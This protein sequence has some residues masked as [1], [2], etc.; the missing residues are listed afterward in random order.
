MNDLASLF[1]GVSLVCAALGAVSFA[2]FSVWLSAVD[3]RSRR[4]PNRVV[5]WGTVLTLG[6]TLASGLLAVAGSDNVDALWRLISAA[7]AAT[8]LAL[9]FLALWL[10][11][12]GGFGAGD[13]K[14]APLVGGF[15]VYVGGETALLICVMVAAGIAFAWGVVLRMRRGRVDLP[16]APCLFGGAW[17]GIL[18]AGLSTGV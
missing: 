8:V 17:V 7:V 16:F 11:F 6:L 15:T 1:D 12:P 9:V 13:V 18:T 5:A 2:V 4:L 3:M 10:A 14:I